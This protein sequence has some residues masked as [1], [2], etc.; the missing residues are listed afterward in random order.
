MI[1]NQ[2]D[3]GGNI[4]VVGVLEDGWIEIQQD[5]VRTFDQDIVQDVFYETE[6]VKTLFRTLR[7]IKHTQLMR[8]SQ[9]Q[10]LD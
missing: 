4:T 6:I 3:L 1:I 9:K 7:S 10:E 5:L 2:T 8:L